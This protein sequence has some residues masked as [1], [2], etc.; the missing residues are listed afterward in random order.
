MS[1][2]AIR[3]ILVGQIIGA[4]V[5]VSE[6]ARASA[7]DM[8]SG[9]EF[10]GVRLS[11]DELATQRGKFIT[12]E[13]IS[14]FGISMVT[15]WQGPDGITTTA[16][17]LLRIDF[18]AGG[19]QAAQPQILVGWSRDGD[20]A[21][22]L[23]T[24]SNAAAPG[25]VTVSG[26]GAISPLLA[27][28]SSGVV[29]S[30]VISGDDSHTLNGMTIAVVPTSSIDKA[31][32]TGLTSI[33]SNQTSTFANGDRLQ[34]AL[35]GGTLGLLIGNGTNVAQQ[36]VDNQLSQASQSI[37]LSDG[38]YSAF[39]LMAITIGSDLSHNPTQINVEQMM[40]SRANLGF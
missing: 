36:R 21:L 10:A 37:A 4:F 7:T 32:T 18:A 22:D 29:Q 35:G 1:H 33:T 19:G 12:P 31:S 28:N 17:L 8:P 6:P 14:Y 20:K 25:Y 27:A 23:A 11:D 39:N 40:L 3:L 9:V 13:S 24:F 15:S 2:T 26:T 16:N 34:F 38:G 5:L 30:N